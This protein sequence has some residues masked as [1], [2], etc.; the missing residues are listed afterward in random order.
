MS[1]YSL[2]GI[3]NVG[4]ALASTGW[5]VGDWLTVE[6]KLGQ[7]RSIR[8]A[9]LVGLIMSLGTPVHCQCVYSGDGPN[10]LIH[11]TCSVLVQHS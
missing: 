10:M 11:T 3:T 4:C 2:H 7:G 1:G 9:I 8:L 6:Y 5:K